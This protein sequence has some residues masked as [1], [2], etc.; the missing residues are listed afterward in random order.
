MG[1]AR[2]DPQWRRTLLQLLFGFFPS[3]VIHAAARLRIADVLAE[4]PRTSEELAAVT[5]THAP[6]L[7]RLLRAMACL[8]MLD[9]TEPGTFALTPLGAPL[10]SDSPD[11]VRS[12][13]MLFCDEDTWRPW[14]HLTYSVQTGEPAFD[15]LHGVHAMD[16]E[17][18]DRNPERAR[19]FNQAMAESTRQAVPAL[20]AAYDF[21][22]FG[23]VVDV[24]GGTGTLLG[25]VLRAAPRLK[26]VLFDTRTGLAGSDDV[27]DEASVAERCRVVQGDFFESVPAGDVHLVKSVIHDWDD[28]RCMVILRNCRAAVAPEGRLVMIEPI[29]PPSAERSMEAIGMVMSDL[30]MLVNTGGRE[31]TRAEF[32]ALLR[33][34]GYALGATAPLPPTNYSLIE[35]I[36]K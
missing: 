32:D 5:G 4:G 15:H 27:L 31:R 10:R 21:N 13:A 16:P 9:E 36:P 19:V 28:D 1:E 23:T 30:N 35:G 17:W 20:V 26:G 8:G 29:L 18:F 6:S 24:G 12:L 3:Q 25:G 14:A 11:S 7:R 22:R 2:S 34:A 33:A